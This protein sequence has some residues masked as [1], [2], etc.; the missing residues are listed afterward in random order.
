MQV[1]LNKEQVTTRLVI[2]GFNQPDYIVMSGQD[3]ESLDLF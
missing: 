3:V 1:S 2:Q